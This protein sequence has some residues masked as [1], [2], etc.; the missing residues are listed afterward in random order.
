MFGL[1]CGGF[2]K[3]KTLHLDSRQRTFRLIQQAWLC[4]A[5][6]VFLVLFW[7]FLPSHSRVLVQYQRWQTPPDI[8]NQSV[9][10]GKHAGAPSGPAGCTGEERRVM[11][12]RAWPPFTTLAL[13][14]FSWIKILAAYQEDSIWI[15]CSLRLLL[16][17]RLFGFLVPRTKK[18]KKQAIC[19]SKPLKRWISC[20]NKWK[21]ST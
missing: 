10:G 18:K 6:N 21:P 11:V 7:F 2:Y 4:Y 19:L 9:R 8:I 15:M 3:N 12:F 20:E 14:L 1:C 13:P 16:A 17:T 5:F